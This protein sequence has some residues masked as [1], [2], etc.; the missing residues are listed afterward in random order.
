MVPYDDIEDGTYIKAKSTIKDMLGSV[1]FVEGDIVRVERGTP[2]GMTG[3]YV[4]CRHDHSANIEFYLT[5]T[6]D[7]SIALL[8]FD[9]IAE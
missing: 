9:K 8:A 2:N 6:P 7:G 4:R 1:C 5:G 3:L